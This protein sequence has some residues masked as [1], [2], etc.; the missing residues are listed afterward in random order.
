MSRL[1]IPLA[2]AGICAAL[3]IVTVR[4]GSFVAGGSDSSCYVLQAERWA[5]G[6]LLD[7]DPLAL[8]ASWPDAERAFAPAGHFPAPRVRGAIAPICPSGLSMLMAPFRAAGGRTAMFL[9][10]PLCGMLLV[11][12]TFLL[13]NRL[14]PG[15]G[16]AS[17]LVIAANPIVLYQVVQPMSDVPAAAFWTLALAMAVCR[18]PRGPLLAGMWAAVAILVRP[19]LLP[20]GFVI[21]VYLLVQPDRF[22][23]ERVA[24]AAA[25]AVPCAAGC[26][27]V[28]LVQ[29]RFYGS[30]L[31]SGYGAV[32]DIFAFAHVAPNVSRY[33]TWL[34]ETQTPLVLLV[35]AAPF[36]LPRA[37]ALLGLAFTIAAAA[38]YLPYLVFE[39]WSYVRFLLPAMPVLTV[40]LLGTVSSLVQRLS[41]RHGATVVSVVAL[42]LALHGVWAARSHQA[43]ALRQLES[44]YARTGGEVDRR[45]PRNALVVTSRYSGSVRYYAG[46]ETLVWDVLDPASLDRAVAFAH[47]HG[48]APFFMLDSGEEEA[49]R[50]RFAGSDLARLDWPPRIEIAP[51][52]R[53]YEP[54]A[55]ERYQRGESIATEYVR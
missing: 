27:A 4:A 24:H 13:G 3:L 35:L 7:P 5:S 25:Y 55:R 1:L 50:M 26:V 2:L 31:A 53:I 37:F 54:A 11:I 43:F 10:F 41:A 46:R 29:W 17:A 52:V 22:W 34:A 45:L 21:G 30:P 19:N 39:D 23:R 47:A 36:A 12:G 44:V 6:R 8:Q 9:L 40:L 38:V 33:G 51:Q 18:E 49:F 48:L 20:L 14:H 15:V 32:G 42:A 16:L 28:A